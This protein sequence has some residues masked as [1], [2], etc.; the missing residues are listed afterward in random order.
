MKVA[1]S[2]MHM[3]QS[4]KKHFLAKF[5]KK[6]SFLVEKLVLTEFES[7]PKNHDDNTIFSIVGRLEIK[8]RMLR[9]LSVFELNLFPEDY[10]LL[11][12]RW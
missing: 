6:K 10:F 5:E 9:F 1:K 3:L 4:S 11:K 8:K 7:Q 2:F 12:K